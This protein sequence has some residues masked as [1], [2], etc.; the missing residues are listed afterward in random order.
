MSFSSVLST[1]FTFT[2]CF[3]TNIRNRSRNCE[4]TSLLCVRRVVIEGL[5][6]ELLPPGQRLTVNQYGIETLVYRVPKLQVEP[7]DLLELQLTSRQQSSV[8]LIGENGCSE[9]SFCVVIPA[10]IPSLL[11]FS[12]PQGLPPNSSYFPSQSWQCYQYVQ[13]NRYIFVLCPAKPKV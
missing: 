2:S 8:P 4:I 13:H 5:K 10:V 3:C 11:K 6:P 1:P 12:S 9:S 7:E